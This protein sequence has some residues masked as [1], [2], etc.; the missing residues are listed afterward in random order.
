MRPGFETENINVWQL[1]W[2]PE[3]SFQT[4]GKNALVPPPL[5]LWEVE[6]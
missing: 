5:C 3:Q 6:D 4:D 1:N 2:S